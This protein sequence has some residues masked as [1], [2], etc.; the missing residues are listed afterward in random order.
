M[1]I[2][3]LARL[4]RAAS[5]G[6]H[7][8]PLQEFIDTLTFPHVHPDHPL[9]LALERMGK[10][11]LDVLPVVSRANYRDMLG[12]VVLADILSSF[13]VDPRDWADREA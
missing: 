11:K 6:E 10:A 13:G 1:G 2:I 3:G 8:K 4:Q 7:E 12:I 9:D 5:D